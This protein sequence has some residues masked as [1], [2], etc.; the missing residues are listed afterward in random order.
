MPIS[1]DFVETDLES[2]VRQFT[3]T[4]KKLESKIKR[5]NRSFFEHNWYS[6][7]K[8]SKRVK[9]KAIKE[10]FDCDG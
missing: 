6:F 8:M 9:D 3:Y 1:P 5:F 2:L 10:R 4:S 7:N